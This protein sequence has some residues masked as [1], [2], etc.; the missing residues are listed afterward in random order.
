LTVES[1]HEFVEVVVFVGF[2]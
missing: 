2:Y 1:T